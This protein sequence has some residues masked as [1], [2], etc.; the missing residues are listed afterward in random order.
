MKTES[1]NFM[2]KNDIVITDINMPRL[3][4]LNG[5]LTYVN[6]K[7]CKLSGYSKEELLGT[8]HNIVRHKD[9]PASEYTDL[10]H[11]IKHEKKQLY[12]FVESSIEPV[13][14]LIKIDEFLD[15]EKLYGYQ[16]LHEIQS[17][18]EATLTGLMPDYLGFDKH[19]LLGNGEYIF[20]R[21]LE[22]VS[23]EFMQ[24]V[25]EELKSLQYQVNELKIDVVEVE[26]DISIMV[27]ISSGD[28][29][30]ENVNCGMK[31]LEYSKQD[32]IVAHNLAQTEQ[33]K[34]KNNLN[35]LRMVKKALEDYKIISYFQPIV[36]NTTQKIV[37]YESLVRLVDE[38]S[39]KA[40]GDTDKIITINIS[41]LDIEK[42]STKE[43]IFELLEDD[44]VRDIEEISK[45]ISEVKGYG[46]E[47]AID[48]FG[49][50]YYFGKPDVLS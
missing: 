30:I 18:F 13:L 25:I 8:N 28:K 31:S 42:P 43:K 20:A 15:I 32:F 22:I 27:S 10:W 26:Y 16:L 41:A 4:G 33:E 11:C 14:I 44:D 19:F 9:T 29:C 40:L 38:N 46:V 2:K 3:N 34:A 48:D 47:I 37:K 35:V 36:C 49:A 24:N 1:R 6:D 45:F 17:N 50:G 5:V 23:E 7:F 39:F 12:D 21:D